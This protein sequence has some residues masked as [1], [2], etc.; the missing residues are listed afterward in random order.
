M[1]QTCITYIQI[2]LPISASQI[3]WSMYWSSNMN[4]NN[5]ISY[6]HHAIEAKCLHAIYG[7]MKSI[8]LKHIEEIV[9]K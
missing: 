8:K 2:Q 1:Y 7:V 6:K 3:V 5:P 4:R 9:S